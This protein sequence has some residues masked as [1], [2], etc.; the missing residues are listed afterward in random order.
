MRKISFLLLAFFIISAQTTKAQEA[1]QEVRESIGALLA[2]NMLGSYSAV[3]NAVTNHIKSTGL[4]RDSAH[5]H[6]AVCSGTIKSSIEYLKKMESSEIFTDDDK[7][8]IR[9]SISIMEK[10]KGSA[11]MYLKILEGDNAANMDKYYRARA[12]ARSSIFEILGIEED[13]TY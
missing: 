10:I 3:T 11:D 5:S 4:S 2:A 6:I 1:H 7:E 13:L 9:K 12:N 8:F